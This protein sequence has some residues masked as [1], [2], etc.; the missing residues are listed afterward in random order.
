MVNMVVITSSLLLCWCS[1]KYFLTTTHIHTLMDPLG[2]I[3]HS[4]SLAKDTLTCGLKKLKSEPPT[5][6]LVEPTRATTAR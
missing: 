2:T 4:I 3:W 5:F 1:F 6:R